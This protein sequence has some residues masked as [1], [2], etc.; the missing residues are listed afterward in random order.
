MI[1]LFTCSFHREWYY[2]LRWLPVSGRKKV[3]ST[4]S[5]NWGKMEKRLKMDESVICFLIRS[6]N[7]QNLCLIKKS[8][9]M[10]NSYRITHSESVKLFVWIQADIMSKPMLTNCHLEPLNN[11]NTFEWNSIHNNKKTKQKWNWRK[12][13]YCLWKVRN[14]VSAPMWL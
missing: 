10:K 6:C 11:W 8:N 1:L 3:S 4:R 7:F 2:K 13:T 14:F 12:C 5:G 9:T